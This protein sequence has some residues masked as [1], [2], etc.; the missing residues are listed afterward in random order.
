MSFSTA[1]QFHTIIDLGALAHGRQH[2]LSLRTDSFT[3]FTCLPVLGTRLDDS[4]DHPKPLIKTIKSNSFNHTD[5]PRAPYLFLSVQIREEVVA[6]VHRRIVESQLLIDG[7]DLLH[8][9]FGKLE[10]ALEVR[11][12]PMGSLALRNHRVANSD[13]PCKRNLRARLVVLLSD[14][15]E[16]RVINQLADV[17]TVDLVLVAEWRVVRDV[18]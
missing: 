12:N 13:A 6:E 5:A 4:M 15:V 8:V 3:F 10:V 18:D 9:L 2:S 11:L 7:L 1:C 14:L 17:G 16:R